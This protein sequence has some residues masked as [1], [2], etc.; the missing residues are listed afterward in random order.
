MIIIKIWYENDKWIR[1]TEINNGNLDV[2]KNCWEVSNNP[3]DPLVYS[4]RY[5]GH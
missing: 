5:D 4:A 1:I 3:D 2:R